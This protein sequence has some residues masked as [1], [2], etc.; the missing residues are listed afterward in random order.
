MIFERPEALLVEDGKYKDLLL[1]LRNGKY[2]WA[3]DGIDASVE[4]MNV[5]ENDNL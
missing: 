3:T 4:I 1:N 2:I 5:I